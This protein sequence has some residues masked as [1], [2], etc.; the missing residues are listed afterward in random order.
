LGPHAR[1]ISVRAAPQERVSC[2]I[3]LSP[4]ADRRTI[5]ASLEGRGGVVRSW[6]E[7]MRVVTA[8]LPATDLT[9]VADLPGVDYVEAAEPFGA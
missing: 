3:R 8:D 5:R 1:R 4:A 2:L 7:E 9:T 6:N